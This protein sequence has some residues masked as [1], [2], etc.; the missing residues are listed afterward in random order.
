MID[1]TVNRDIQKQNAKYCKAK[2]IKLPTYAMMKGPRPGAGRGQGQTE[3]K[4]G[5]GIL[6]P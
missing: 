2:G 4:Q 5:F 3:K 6:I 1:F